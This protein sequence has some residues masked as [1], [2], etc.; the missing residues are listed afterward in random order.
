MSQRVHLIWACCWCK[1]VKKLASLFGCSEFLLLLA[2]AGTF[3]AFIVLVTT[4]MK[5]FL[6]GHSQ[7][8]LNQ[9]STQMHSGC[10]KRWTYCS[11]TPLCR[12]LFGISSFHSTTWQATS[13]L[14]RASR[15]YKPCRLSCPWL[16]SFFLHLLIILC[17]LWSPLVLVIPVTKS[18][19]GL[20]MSGQSL[21][22]C[23]VTV[24]W[25]KGYAPSVWAFAS[26]SQVFIMH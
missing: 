12:R 9:T 5:I 7:K 1:S 26:T 3:Q 6:T 14:W 18:M 16:L 8:Y 13:A 19:D 10:H 20:Q 25:W 2:V 24:L 4:T 11:V 22:L 21:L 15:V 23:S 17:P